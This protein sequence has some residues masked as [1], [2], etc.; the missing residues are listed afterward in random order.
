VPNFVPRVPKFVPCAHIG[1]CRP[2]VTSVILVK[3]RKPL[4]DSS[5]VDVER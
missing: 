1:R 4:W 3:M 5:L 2:M